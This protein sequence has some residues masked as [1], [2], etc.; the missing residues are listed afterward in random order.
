MTAR[1]TPAKKELTQK[2]IRMSSTLVMTRPMLIR[3]D[4]GGA[5]GSLLQPLAV[6][7]VSRC[8]ARK[9]NLSVPR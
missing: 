3:R 2:N 1:V 4:H 6:D 8:L 9:L 5:E 7:G